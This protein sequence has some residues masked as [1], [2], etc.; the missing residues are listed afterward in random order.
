MDRPRNLDGK[1]DRHD[2]CIDSLEQPL[3]TPVQEV[4]IRVYR[5]E[6]DRQKL[7][8]RRRRSRKAACCSS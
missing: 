1:A 3:L 5:Q 2:A 7:L 4:L 6:A 8:P